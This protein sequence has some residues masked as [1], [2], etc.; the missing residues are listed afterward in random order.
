MFGVPELMI[1]GMI[2]T[3]WIVPLVAGIW[4]LMT[5]HRLRQT[6]D[7]IRATLERIEQSL[8]RR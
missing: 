8:P 5:L 7:A 3:L 2:G 4:A 6:Q 1:V